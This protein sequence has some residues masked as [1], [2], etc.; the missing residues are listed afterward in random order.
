MIAFRRG[1]G[2]DSRSVQTDRPAG[3]ADL[4]PVQPE[5]RRPRRRSASVKSAAT[6]KSQRGC[7]SAS[8]AISTGES[9]VRQHEREGG[10]DDDEQPER[11][12][13]Q[14]A[15]E[16][17]EDRPDDPVD[18]DEDAR[19]RGSRRATPFPTGWTIGA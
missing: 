2:S 19:P 4:W 7:G 10:D 16:R 12:E 18:D 15:E 11:R 14:A 17:H 6:S 9:R 5:E 3:L 8:T 1:V 13:E